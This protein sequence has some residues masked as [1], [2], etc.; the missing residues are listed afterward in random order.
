MYI[1]IKTPD[2]ER[3][4]FSLFGFFFLSA[5]LEIRN[6]QKTPHPSLQESEKHNALTGKKKNNINSLLS[7]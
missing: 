6:L 3:L 5:V 1:L 7:M 2:I 4:P